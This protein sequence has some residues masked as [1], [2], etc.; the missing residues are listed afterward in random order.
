M[1]DGVHH[2]PHFH[3]YSKSTWVCSAL[4]PVDLIAGDLPRAQRRLVEAWAGARATGIPIAQPDT[5]GGAEQVSHVSPVRLTHGCAALPIMNVQLLEIVSDE[6]G[7]RSWTYPRCRT[8][9]ELSRG[10]KQ[11]LC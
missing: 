2:T 3:A 10:R 4:D 9:K 6:L 7:V 5:K 11:A 8:G 1:E